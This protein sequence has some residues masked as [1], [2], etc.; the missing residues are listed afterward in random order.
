MVKETQKKQVKIS[1]SKPKRDKKGRLL[2]GNTANPKGL[3]VI[4]K[5]ERDKRKT[6]KKA[7]EQ[8]IKEYKEGLAKV[9]PK[10]EPVLVK[11]ALSGD[12]IAIKEIH[13]RVMGN[14]LT[15]IDVTS[16]GEKLYKWGEFG[17][18]KIKKDDEKV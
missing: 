14:P 1:K 10:L 16:G 18:E 15:P 17:K 8:F 7:T 11:K 6:I 4:T 12:M 2:P 3:A 5:K 13:S 9:L